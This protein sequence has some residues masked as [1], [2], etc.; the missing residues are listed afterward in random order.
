MNFSSIECSV[1]SEKTDSVNIFNISGF[2]PHIFNILQAFKSGRSGG[3]YLFWWIFKF[4]FPM[5]KVNN[6]DLKE[7]FVFRL[8]Q[9]LAKAILL[10]ASFWLFR[11]YKTTRDWWG[12][13]FN[14]LNVCQHYEVI[15]MI[16]DLREKS[17]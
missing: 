11:I 1:E 16:N 2:F 14:I 6:F 9:T 5:K 10:N 15:M 17:H 13:Q 12:D 7:L 8:P 3:R 4:C